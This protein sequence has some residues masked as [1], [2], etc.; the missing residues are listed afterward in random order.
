MTPRESRSL[1]CRGV[2]NVAVECEGRSLLETDPLVADLVS[3]ETRRQEEKVT[4]IASE[5]RPHP[6]VLEAL[7]SPL[8]SLYAEGYAP[9]RLR[10][11]SLAELTDIDA[12]LAEHQQLGNRR[13]YEGAEIADLVESI[14]EQRA[15]QCFAHDACRET[16]IHANVQALSGSAANLAIYQALLEP[17]DTILAMALAKGGHLPHGSPYSTTGQRYN[18][19][20][21]HTDPATERLDDDAIERLAREHR[22]KLIVGGFTS[23]PWASD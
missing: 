19:V 5:S 4:L 9:Q 10:T 11:A 18:A 16:D 20:F 1:V 14:A 3:R 7:A 2:W 6:A 22:P 21:Y 15:A 12:R 13:Y 23:Y 8:T 17:G